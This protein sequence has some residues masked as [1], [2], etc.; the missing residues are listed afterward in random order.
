MIERVSV[1]IP[2]RN[3]AD[4]IGE[5]LDAVFAQK[6]R[7]ALD[8]VVVDSASTDATRALLARHPVRIE[9]IQPAD[10]DHGATR[11]LGISLSR[12]QVVVLL[13]Q[14]AIPA[15]GALIE[16][17]VRPFEEPDVAGVFARQIPRPDCDV[18]RRRQLES[19]LTGRRD[20]ARVSLGGVELDSLPPFERYERCVF[21]N[22]CSALRR[23]VWEEI[24]FPRS[25]FGEDIAW[26]RAVLE[27]GWTLAYEPSAAVV[28]SHRRPIR[29][30]YRRERDAHRRLYELFGLAVVPRR[31]DVLRGIWWQLRNELP[32][33]WR[34]VPSGAERWRQLARIAGLS[35]AA[36][37]GQHQGY[38]DAVRTGGRSA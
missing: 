7:F 18:V 30:E 9:T 26:G 27:A 38:R 16:N 8:V 21:D 2:T 36:P 1:V 35:V 28:H 3:G 10:F 29:E 19:W 6:H 20:P 33:V 11:N 23:D 4:T 32:Y 5:V 25:A 31:R 15:D 17:L 22:V 14:D 13:T 24:P 34:H 12:G 37:I